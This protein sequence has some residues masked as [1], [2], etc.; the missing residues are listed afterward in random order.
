M[1]FNFGI[2]FEQLR[3][4]ESQ[5]WWDWEDTS[6]TNW[7]HC[8][9][10]SNNRFSFLLVQ[11]LWKAERYGFVAHLYFYAIS[12]SSNLILNIYN[13]LFLNNVM[14]VVNKEC[15]VDSNRIEHLSLLFSGKLFVFWWSIF[16]FFVLNPL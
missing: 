14:Q 15:Y 10:W 7:T 16:P 9:C 4:W 13:V 3:W 11:A 5:W 8:W 6:H 12:I 1:L 2:E